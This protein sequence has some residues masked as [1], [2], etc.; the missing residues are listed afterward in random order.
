MSN[1]MY[2]Y[3]DK[4]E[5]TEETGQWFQHDPSTC[6]AIY[7]KEFSYASFSKTAAGKILN[8]VNIIV[9][10]YLDISICLNYLAEL[11]LKG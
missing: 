7:E 5:N 8:C 1:S 11:R 6:K 3:P 9:S 4:M 2:K 10:L